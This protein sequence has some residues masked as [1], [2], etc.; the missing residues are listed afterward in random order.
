MDFL[1]LSRNRI[2]LCVL[3]FT[4]LYILNECILVINRLHYKIDFK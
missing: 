3:L 2:I 4:F 1:K